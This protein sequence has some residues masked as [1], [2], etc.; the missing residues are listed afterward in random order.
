MRFYTMH[1]ISGASGSDSE[2]TGP[3]RSL[4]SDGRQTG[5]SEIPSVH[6]DRTGQAA[7]AHALRI[8]I[9]TGQTAASHPTGPCVHS[10]SHGDRKESRER[11]RSGSRPL[12]ESSTSPATS[13]RLGGVLR[14][15]DLEY[16]GNTVTEEDTG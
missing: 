10:R 15:K 8:E 16:P 11:K 2:D 7:V 14:G 6:H 9:P 1:I 4:R 5:G 12:E 3:E 13:G